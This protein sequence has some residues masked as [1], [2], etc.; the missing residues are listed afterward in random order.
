MS[1]LIARHT[2]SNPEDEKSSAMHLV[3]LV[4]EA[5]LEV[6]CVS[7]PGYIIAKAGMFDT[8]NQKFI[9]NLNVSLFTP[10][11]SA[12]P[13]RSPEN[14][15]LIFENSFHK[16]SK[17]AYSIQARGTS[18]YP[19]DI[20]V[21]D[22]CELELLQDDGQAL[23]P[24]QTRL[25]LCYRHGNHLFLYLKNRML[26]HAGCVRQLQLPPHLPRPL[27]LHDHLR[28]PLGPNPR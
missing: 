1:H 14:Q 5:V 27:S 19:V 16:A 26:I 18:C 25:Q 28:P 8:E 13:C 11:L 2:L 23:S 9:A 4:S 20:C 7:A 24:R 10:C 21:Y 17:S 3:L 22:T 15:V 12:Y 6:V